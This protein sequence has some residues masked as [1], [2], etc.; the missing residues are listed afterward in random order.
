M[1]IR[2]SNSVVATFCH[3][4]AHGLPIEVR[5]PAYSLPLVYIDDAVQSF[6]AA[7]E[8]RAARDL[9][10]IHIC[11]SLSSGPRAGA[12]S[13]ITPPPSQTNAEGQRLSAGSPLSGCG[14]GRIFC[15][16]PSRWR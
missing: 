11:S 3:N 7:L 14:G 13:F 2:D 4:I 9:S 10:L 1:C 16:A 15:A 8:G 5:D 12:N 6:L